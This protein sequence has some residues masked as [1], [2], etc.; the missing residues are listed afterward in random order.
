MAWPT[1]LPARTGPELIGLLAE[2]PGTTRLAIYTIH[3]DGSHPRYV[4][5]APGGPFVT[6]FGFVWSPN[7]ASILYSCG[8]GPRDA[9]WQLCTVNTATGGARRLTHAPAGYDLEPLA[10]GPRTIAAQ[11]RQDE[12]CLVNPTTGAITQIT[13]G[14]PSNH[15]GYVIGAGV[16]SPNGATLALTCSRVNATATN[17]ICLLNSNNQLTFESTHYTI[18]GVE[19]WTADSEQIIWWGHLAKGGPLTY[20]KQN[21][22]GTGTEPLNG[23]EI[24]RGPHYSP[25]GHTRLIRKGAQGNLSTEPVVGG[26]PRVILRPGTDIWDWAYQPR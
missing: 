10:W 13:H 2:I 11:C 26:T 9:A 23:P 16:W 24:I 3:A 20:Y 19:G 12:L 21:A 1:I 6:G 18:T 15:D 5:A 17:R 22:D 25:D 14:G 4:A 7:G 8:E